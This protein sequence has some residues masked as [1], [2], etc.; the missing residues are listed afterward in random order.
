VLSDVSALGQSLVQRS[1]TE[2]GV[3]ECDSESLT[4]R[5]PWP[6]RAVAPW[7]LKMG[8]I[9]RGPSLMTSFVSAEF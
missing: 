1:P 8:S 6:T 7:H 5:K 2:C 3:S 9:K 4:M